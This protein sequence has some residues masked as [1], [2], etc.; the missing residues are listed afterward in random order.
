M[1]QMHMQDIELLATQNQLNRVQQLV[2]ERAGEL[3]S[4][5]EL[6]AADTQ[7]LQEME[8]QA[9]ELKAE[10]EARKIV[11]DRLRVELNLALKERDQLQDRTNRLEAEVEVL[12]KQRED[13]SRREE[14]ARERESLLLKERLEASERESALAAELAKIQE[15]EAV[16]RLSQLNAEAAL[17]SARA[18]LEQKKRAMEARD[19]ELADLL[20]KK[21]ADLSQ[22][23]LAEKNV[24]ASA[25]AAV[26]AERARLQAELDADR[27]RATASEAD[28]E[29]LRAER[30]A[31]QARAAAAGSKAKQLT[32]QI[33]KAAWA[34]AEA[35]SQV[36]ALQAELMDMEMRAALREKE[37]A[38]LQQRLLSMQ[39]LEKDAAAAKA[40]L[41]DEERIAREHIQATEQQLVKLSA[42]GRE[43][44]AAVKDQS[45]D[46]LR[47]K[48]ERDDLQERAEK[49]AAE[50][51]RLRR[52]AELREADG[53]DV[54]D[55]LQ[56]LRVAQQ[57]KESLQRAN[58][59][60]VQQL[61]LQQQQRE[62]REGAAVQILS[63]LAEQKSNMMRM[64]QELE[65]ELSALKAEEAGAKKQGD[66]AEKK[67]RD[68]EKGLAEAAS[69]RAEAEAEVDRLKR[70]KAAQVFRAQNL[71]PSY[72]AS[73]P[74]ISNFILSLSSNVNPESKKRSQ[75]SRRKRETAKM[76]S[77]RKRA[78]LT[79]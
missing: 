77:C 46:V 10:A 26:E 42:R 79:N 61:L 8:Q 49:L 37:R 70:E 69:K 50:V 14:Q 65:R 78:R 18:E 28:V 24:G 76:K 2:Q 33:D 72:P 60:T 74:F 38:Q 64:Q 56:R 6:A 52:D 22:S 75:N 30:A 66:A 17:Q 57:E 43:A 44:D 5:K 29:R 3:S 41:I 40:S 59:A 68:M 34:E 71:V 20:S 31:V 1:E 62:A 47:L 19:R 58:E 12:R 35:S 63:E 27:A 36:N 67:R 54:A 4:L 15:V 16:T 9:A 73:K 51:E 39:D 45:S 23:L 53:R 13:S 32:K 55:E 11:A 21:M 7:R 25:L 48:Q